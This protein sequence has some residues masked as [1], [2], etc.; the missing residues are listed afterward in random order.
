MQWLNHPIFYA[1]MACVLLQFIAWNQQRRSNNADSV[2]IA[3]TLGIIVC[4]IIY[5]F[6][7]SA[8]VLNMFVV[9]IFPVIWYSRLLYHLIDR[10]DVNHEDSRYQNLRAH[11]SEGTQIKFLSFFMFQAVLSVMFSLTAYWVLTAAVFGT[12]QLSLVLILGSLALLGVSLADR[13][14]LNF[15]RNNDSTQ[16]CDVGLWRYSRHPNYFLNGCIGL[17]ILFFYG[18]AHI[19]GGQ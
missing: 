12:V 8:A 6:M 9:F 7:I 17:P 18:E 19:F 10:Y 1:S 11:W 5:L 15:K 2:D 3:W 13:Q 16:V 14:L 4:A